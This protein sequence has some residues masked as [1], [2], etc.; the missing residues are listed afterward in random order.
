MMMRS[1][2]SRGGSPGKA[3]ACN[4]MSGDRSQTVNRIISQARLHHRSAGLVILNR[5]RDSSMPISQ[6][7]MGDTRGARPARQVSSRV[8]R[9]SLLTGSPLPSQSNAQVSSRTGA[10]TLPRPTPGQ[11][12]RSDQWLR[13]I[14]LCPSSPHSRD[15]DPFR[16][17]QMSPLRAWPVGRSA[18][19]PTCRPVRSQIQPQARPG[20]WDCWLGKAE[21]NPLSGLATEI[22]PQGVI[23]AHRLTPSE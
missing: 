12:V 23:L 19:Q 17:G 3:L 20:S 22:G 8:A 5:P 1:A 6:A 2:G 10:L 4:R 9:A 14:E 13:R 11:Q 7:L 18:A 15:S 16:R 21:G